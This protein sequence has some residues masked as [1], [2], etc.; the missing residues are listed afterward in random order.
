ML[1]G[2]DVEDVLSGDPEAIAELAVTAAR[3]V[4]PES[5]RIG[6]VDVPLDELVEL[7]G[8]PVLRA[9]LEALF[10]RRLVLEVDEGVVVEGTITP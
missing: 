5:L 2:C 9:A 6:D 1:A 3:A 7:V 10:P 8:L 4:L